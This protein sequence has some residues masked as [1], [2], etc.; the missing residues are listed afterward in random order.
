MLN[1]VENRAPLLSKDL[2][3][4]SLDFPV[5]KNFSFFTN[6]KLL[7]EIFQKELLKETEIAKHGF[8]FNK[9]IILLNQKFIKKNIKKKFVYNFDFFQKRYKEYLNGNFEHEQYLWSELMLNFSRQ[10]LN[11]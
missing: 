7:K 4:F 6:K 9:N 8:A 2:L 10:N 11:C 3:N 5:E 1:S